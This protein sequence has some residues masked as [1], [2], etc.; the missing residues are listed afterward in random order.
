MR[1]GPSRSVPH[2]IMRA[3][4]KI[5]RGRS[6][7]RWWWVPLYRGI[8]CLF[9]KIVDMVG[10]EGII[11]CFVMLSDSFSPVFLDCFPQARLVLIAKNRLYSM[12]R[13]TNCAWNGNGMP[14]CA[15][16]SLSTFMSIFPHV[17]TFS[18]PWY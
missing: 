2:L 17:T 16:L 13:S 14:V 3:D 8:S 11:Q 4:Y 1:D 10:G 15:Q 6:G 5:W 18:I 12:D 9:D 7:L